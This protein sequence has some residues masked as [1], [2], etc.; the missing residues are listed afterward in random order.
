MEITLAIMEKWLDVKTQKLETAFR[1]LEDDLAQN[2][3]V[4]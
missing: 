1:L 2:D 3:E 4:R